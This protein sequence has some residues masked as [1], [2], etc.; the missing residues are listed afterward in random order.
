M[1]LFINYEVAVYFED[2]KQELELAIPYLLLDIKA[3]EDINPASIFDEVDYFLNSFLKIQIIPT[4]II[5]L[6]DNIEIAN[7]KD[8]ISSKDIPKRVTKPSLFVVE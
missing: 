4:N 2:M 7:S 6:V 5:I 8:Y 3:E 1:S